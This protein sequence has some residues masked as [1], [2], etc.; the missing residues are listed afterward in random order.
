M[1]ALVKSIEE[2]PKRYLCC[3]EAVASIQTHA[4]GRIIDVAPHHKNHKTSC[5]YC[6]TDFGE[7]KLF[8]VDGD[9]RKAIP[10]DCIHLDEGEI[11]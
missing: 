6:G 1:K 7:T 11:N 9:T 5:P 3:G 2:F 10:V 4:C 8:M